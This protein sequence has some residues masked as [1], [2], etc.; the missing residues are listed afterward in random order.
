MHIAGCRSL[1]E[2]SKQNVKRTYSTKARALHRVF[3][4]LWIIQESTALSFDCMKGSPDG[5][6]SSHQSPEST[7][8]WLAAQQEA[9]PELEDS[10]CE[11]V[12]GVPQDLFVLLGRTTSLVQ[13]IRSYTTAH[14]N[15]AL[16]VSLLGKCQTLED[17]ILEWPV[18]K[19][20]FAGSISN[21]DTDT[22][23]I[24]SHQ[25]RS[26]HQAIII[27]FSQHVRSIHRQHLQPYV[28][29]VIDH[30]EAIED[31]KRRIKLV[32]GPILWPGF[33]AAS[34]ALGKTLQGRFKK[35][36]DL[37]EN[38]Y[39]LGNAGAP[40]AVINEVWERRQSAEEGVRNE[41]SD[42]REVA[43]SKKAYLMLT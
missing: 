8:K 22:R 41:R 21:L 10:T 19:I 30:L 2:T 33:I 37:V 32:A 34:E 24:I 11:L 40:M 23:Q 15:M 3:L 1:I 25:T 18:D 6:E 16:P 26:F 38:N 42:W 29:S 27:F 36:F 20:L 35:W 43:E 39:G 17:E 28:R 12:Y 4:Y 9:T 13:Q 5:D 14:P 7:A 31:I